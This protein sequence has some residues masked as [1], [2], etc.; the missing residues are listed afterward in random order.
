MTPL[1]V[2]AQTD[3]TAGPC[4]PPQEAG[5]LCELVFSA[6]GRPELARAAEVVIDVRR[7]GWRRSPIV[8]G[9]SSERDQLPLGIVREAQR[10]GM[11]G[12]GGRSRTGARAH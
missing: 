12:R 4:G 10:D 9:L 1:S 8:S 2:L 5:W 11:N 6:T 7:L 3:D